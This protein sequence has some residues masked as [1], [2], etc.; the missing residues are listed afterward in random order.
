MSVQLIGGMIGAGHIQ[1]LGN[2]RETWLQMRETKKGL[3]DSSAECCP[4]LCVVHK[5]GANME[6]SKLPHFLLWSQQCVWLFW[7]NESKNLHYST[8]IVVF[9]R[10]LWAVLCASCCVPCHCSQQVSQD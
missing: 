8:R 4:G 9:R 6:V 1:A 3:L 7:V 5:C 10:D 2:S